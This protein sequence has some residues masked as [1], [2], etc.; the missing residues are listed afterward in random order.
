MEASRID[1]A[2]PLWDPL[3]VVPNVRPALWLGL[4]LAVVLLQGPSFIEQLKP[5]PNVGNDFFQ[6]WASARNWRE[7]LPIYRDLRDAVQRYLGAENV[8]IIVPVNAHPPT[9]VLV[10]LP[11]AWFDYPDAVFAWNLVMLAL[12]ALSLALVWRELRIPFR[13]WSLAPVL[14]LTLLCN[15]FRQQ[16][17]L[18]QLNLFL[19]PLLVGFWLAERR[20]RPG[21]AGAALGLATAYKLFPGLLFFY[22]LLRRQ[23]LTLAAALLTFAA[24]TGLTAAVLG[25][26]TYRTYVVDV[27]PQVERSQSGW[28]NLTLTGVWAKLFNPAD[29]RDRVEALWRA[30]LL[31]RMGAL[32]S[33]SAVLGVL[34]WVVG[35]ARTPAERDAAFSLTLTA[36]LLVSPIAWDHYLLLLLVP[37]AVVWTHLP[38]TPAFELPF[39]VILAAFWISPIPVYNA[40]I[41][42]G[43]PSGPARPRH[44]LL[45]LSF[46]CWALLAFGALQIAICRRKES[47]KM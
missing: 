34:A 18:G 19:L 7:G 6:E 24:V 36:M 22:L 31:A 4:A 17:T 15:P 35:K 9:S 38:G 25:V 8:H 12:F 27:L 2:R 16:I 40:F 32:A 14:T 21:W 45:V 43:F 28:G 46:Q 44:T 26:E 30:P 11:L 1:T 20:E 39:L 33:I 29:N 37:L 47:G 5:D 10:A 42:G 3:A 41:P 23:W 13:A